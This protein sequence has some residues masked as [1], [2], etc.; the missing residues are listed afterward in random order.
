[1][2]TWSKSTLG[3]QVRTNSE[4]GTFAREAQASLRLVFVR[5]D[6]EMVSRDKEKGGG[7]TS[8]WIPFLVL[9]LLSRDEEREPYSST[10][11]ITPSFASSDE[12]AV[13]REQVI[14]TSGPKKRGA[15]EEL[16]HL[17]TLTVI[18]LKEKLQ[19]VGLPVSSRNRNKLIKAF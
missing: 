7:G 4:E 16:M 1:M 19:R 2:T 5:T 15:M 14:V 10:T 3:L 13:L 11:R 8:N 12:A 9:I 18:V 17:S 6:K